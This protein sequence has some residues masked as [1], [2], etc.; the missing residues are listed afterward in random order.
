MRSHSMDDKDLAVPIILG[1]DFLREAKITIDFNVSCISLPDT[2]SSHP[3]CFN[4]TP[5]HPAVRFYAAQGEVEGFH[6]K[7]SKLIDQVV[8]NSHA[9]DKV[10]SQLKALLYDW[11]SVCTTNL[12]RTSLIKHE[13]K[14]T[15]ELPLRK[16]PYRVSK[17]KNDFI[18]EQIEELLQ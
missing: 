12:G 15:D 4:K 17:V 11:P 18:E 9:A 7:K 16:R 13:I 2:N 5:K 8:G 10:K 1:L 6:D 3:M 14:T